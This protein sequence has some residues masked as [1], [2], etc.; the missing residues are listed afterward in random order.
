MTRLLAVLTACALALVIPASRAG[1]STAIPVPEQDPFYAVPADVAQY[2]DGAVLDSRAIDARMLGLPLPADAWQ[3]KYKTEDE[4]GVATAT[5]TTVMVPRAAWRHPGPRP[6][7]SYQVAEDGVAG[8]C[9][10]SYALRA[11]IGAGPTNSA[12]ETPVMALALL[13]GWTVAVPDYEGP[14][15]EFL[16]TGVEARGVLD[17]IR[18]V[19]GFAPAGVAADAPT[20]LW[21]Y[22][23][24]SLASVTAAQLQSSYAPDV[25]LRGVALGGLVADI[26]ASIDKFD[27]SYAGGAIPMGINGFLRHYPEL[28][29]EQ[30]LKASGMAKVEASSHDCIYE[31][32]AR[33]P[34]LKLSDIEAVPGAL[35]QP[36]VAAMLDQNSPLY[37]AGTPQ[38]P[39]YHYQSVHDELAPIGPARALLRKFCADGAVV[40]S[41]ERKFGEHLTEVA[42][43]AFGALGFL[44]NRFAG[45]PPVNTCSRIP[46]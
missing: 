44:S 22:S 43:G 9:A 21:G 27:G 28:H 38:A 10:P 4:R 36:P 11:G 20:A 37:R 25:H 41:V 14:R 7:L 6:L 29:L 46:G 12:T 23:G 8:R 17:G 16:V 24:G 45:R 32:A 42:L 18:A 15:S 26:H 19:R 2:P 3:I 31:A 40:Q 33:F 34:L 30:Y 1:S 13:R 5:V 39:I 35:D